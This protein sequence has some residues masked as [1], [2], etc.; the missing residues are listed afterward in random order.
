M[1]EG[2]IASVL[3]SEAL[4]GLSAEEIVAAISAMSDDQIY[5]LL[6]LEAAER[7]EAWSQIRFNKFAN[8]YPDETI[9]RNDGNNEFIFHARRHY[10]KHMLAFRLGAKVRARTFM[11]ANR[12]GKTFGV[13]GYETC[14]HLTGLYPEWWEGAVFK[15]P[16]RAWACGKTNETTRD[17]V[18][19]VLLGEIEFDGPRKVVDGSGMIPHELI[20]MGHGQITFKQG[21][22]DLIDTVKIK[23]VTGGWSK[24]GI[25]SYA[26]G[27]GAFE[28]VAQHFV[29]DDEEPPMDIYGEQII[30]TATT[31]GKLLL[32][33]TPLEG[34]TEVVEQFLPD[35]ELTEKMKAWS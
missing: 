4:A 8:L 14:C 22:A 27:R 11:A 33:Y 5:A 34:L 18:Q 20:G 30:R 2:P 7:N 29:W 23:H 3:N 28:G 12:V 31:K 32:T 26:Q 24:L 13:G 1:L 25:K 15:H 19:T 35:D 21:V 6:S 16:I 9:I 17:I 10:P